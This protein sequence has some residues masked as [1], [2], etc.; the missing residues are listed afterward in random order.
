MPAIMNATHAGDASL[1][2]IFGLDEIDRAV[3]S[4]EIVARS[5]APN[6]HDP[7]PRHALERDFPRVMSAIMG[8]WGTEMCAEYLRSLVMMQPG[9]KRQGFPMELI[10]DLLLLDRCNS[11]L[12]YHG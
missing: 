10:E 9:E 2:S 8:L 11:A 4:N 5:K 3:P 7:D 1:P 12:L 6:P